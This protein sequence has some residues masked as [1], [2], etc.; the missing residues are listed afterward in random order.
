MNRFLQRLSDIT[1]IHHR[2]AFIDVAD[3][4]S[5]K[6]SEFLELAA[7]RYS[8][9][10]FRPAPVEQKM[11]DSIL[12]AG[13]LAPTAVNRQPVHV[14]AIVDEEMRS[15]LTEATKYTFGAPVVFIIGADKKSA[16]VRKN[17]GKTSAEIDASIVC[18]HMMLEVA[19]LGLGST[20]VGSFD[21]EIVKKILPQ[22]ADYEV[23]ALLPVG[24]PADG[25]SANHD[26]RIEMEK[27]ATII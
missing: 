7:K 4:I 27:F 25:A 21:E 20:W 1:K 24:H 2:A 23:L 8:C 16:W 14:W 6:K 17:D 19:D 12:E 13:R 10:S 26:I 3:R 15:R 5:P 18:T 9:R 22:T 11:I